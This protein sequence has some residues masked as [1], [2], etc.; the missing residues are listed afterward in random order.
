MP[1][2]T[3]PHDVYAVPLAWRVLFV[4]TTYV[5]TSE[6]HTQHVNG[7]DE[8]TDQVQFVPL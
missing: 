8:V 5:I 6:S 7:F 4:L 2:A 1:A 3:V